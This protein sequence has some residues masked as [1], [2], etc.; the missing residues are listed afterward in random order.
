[1]FMYASPLWR[2]RVHS[3]GLC[4]RSD[5]EIC[6]VK[7]NCTMMICVH[8]KRGHITRRQKPKSELGKQ[9]DF[10]MIQDRLSN[11]KVVVWRS[12]RRFDV[13]ACLHLIY[14]PPVI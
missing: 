6:E 14:L 12:D 8:Q 10:W 13:L 5:D 7:M 3:R 4:A 9:L 2:S 1:M 11:S